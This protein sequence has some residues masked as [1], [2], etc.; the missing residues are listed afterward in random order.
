MERRHGRDDWVWR[1]L[2]AVAVWGVRVLA[3]PSALS[4]ILFIA[5]AY[6]LPTE[7]AEPLRP[8][9]F[10]C[11]NNLRGERCTLSLVSLEPDGYYKGSGISTPLWMDHEEVA[12]SRAF[13]ESIEN[14]DTVYAVRTP[15]YANIR[16]VE[17][18]EGG[19]SDGSYQL[20]GLTLFA[21]AGLL[22]LLYWRPSATDLWD[23]YEESDDP[24]DF[25][26]P[27]EPGGRP[28][29]ILV[30]VVTLEITMIVP[31]IKLLR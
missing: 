15:L 26:P 12:V 20:H 27:P 23:G 13:V 25:T 11:K 9:R 21:L 8:T 29:Q 5:D 16:N 30:A 2:Y 31:L 4:A 18:S 14:A 17:L 3:L 24:D 7:V 22:P 10:V 28:W 6:L 19:R 1:R